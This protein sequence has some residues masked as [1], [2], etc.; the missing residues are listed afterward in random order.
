VR[1][2]LIVPLL[3][4]AATVV[5]GGLNRLVSDKW[6]LAAT[7]LFNNAV[8]LVISIGVWA[9]VAGAPGLFPAFF[10]DRGGWGDIRWW[11]IIP[12]LAGLVIVGG[13]PWA[14]S[15]LGALAVL[16]GIVAAQMVV[17][18]AWDAVMEGQ[19]VTALRF[20]GAALA[21]AGVALA[22]WQSG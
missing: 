9:V 7:I 2:M 12:A 10:A 20:G 18:L 1:W 3:V 5:Q 21:V 6:G 14:I 4:G 19:P 16:V 17:G 22:S 8:L 13:I 15:R 11:W